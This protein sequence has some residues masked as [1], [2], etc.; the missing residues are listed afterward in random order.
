MQNLDQI[1]LLSKKISFDQ[2][3]L[4][5]LSQALRI[6]IY[7]EYK[8]FEFYKVVISKHGSNTLFTNLM[9]A[10]AKHFEELIQLC[11]KHEI[12]PPINDLQGSIVAANTL[13]ECY[14][15]GVANEL[16]NIYMYDYLLPYVGEYP[17]VVDAFYRLQAA[18][19]NNHLPTLR[20]HVA[21][22]NQDNAMEKLGELSQMA[23][24]IANK[25]V[26]PEEITKLLNQSNISLITGLLTGGVGGVALNQFFTDKEK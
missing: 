6:A 2:N 18:S 13:K 10:E 7:D 3:S 25:E 16:E 17:D 5:V 26:R 20:T 12:T 8:T 19:Y 1:S 9:Q 11:K 4:P 23:N 22:A 24:K 14:E 15:I 21:N